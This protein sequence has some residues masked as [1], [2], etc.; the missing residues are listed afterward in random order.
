MEQLSFTDLDEI[1]SDN[2]LS[3]FSL[4][5]PSILEDFPF[6]EIYEVSRK[7]ASRKKPIFFIHKYFA[8]R[9]T[10]NFRLALLSLLFEGETDIWSKFYDSNQLSK[11]DSLTI[12]D[13][14]M[15]G[16]TTIFE[17]LRIGANVIGNDLQPLSRLVTE[18]EVR[19]LDE[20]RLKRQLDILD[21]RVGKKIK[22]Y[23]KTDCPQCDK[24]ADVMYNFHVKQA[25][26]PTSGRI[27]DLYSS[28]IIVS[29][30]GTYTLCCPKC[31]SLFKNDFQNGQ[32]DCP[33]CNY[34][35]DSPNDGFVKRGEYTCPETGE[36]FMLR[37][38]DSSTGYP[39]KT[40]LIAQE[41]YCTH[42]K[43]HDY[44]EVTEK[45]LSIHESALRDFQE[46]EKDLI[47]PEQE[48]PAGYNTNQ[49]INHG[50]GKFRDLFTD[51]QLL[52]LGLLLKEID[53]LEDEESK[54]WLMV[55]FSAQL[56]MNNTFC[57]YQHNA[58]KISNIFFNHAYV[59]ISMPVENNIWGT[60]LGT[61]T[62]IKGVNKIIKGKAFNNNIYD[63]SVSNGKSGKIFSKDK[64]NA[65]PV[66]NY[67]KLDKG[68]PLITNVDSR[69][70]E[71]IPSNS[72][73]VILTDPPYGSNVMY[74]ELI[75][76]FHV[77]IS[78]TD[79]GKDNG[80]ITP[81]SPKTEEV[82]VNNVQKKTYDD[83][84]DGLTEIFQEGNRTLKDEGYLMFT[85]HDNSLNGW[86]SV[87][88]SL[89]QSNFELVAAYP[90]HSET[91]TGAHTSAKNSIAFDIFLVCRKKHNIPESDF[92][93]STIEAN[94]LKITNNFVERLNNINAE[95]T[96][97]DIENIFI[98]QFFVSCFSYHF[99]SWDTLDNIIIQIKSILKQLDEVFNDYNI[100]EKRTGWWSNTQGKV[101]LQ[102]LLNAK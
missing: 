80:F 18:A 68:N 94:A 41:Y 82:I 26:S 81:T 5:N 67:K 22:S 93:F 87:I 96:I 65:I 42:C 24:E 75:D 50:Y 32:A 101:F 2:K 7:E 16:G 4:Q 77:W 62:F 71:H 28:F 40:K 11:E 98:S 86:I 74:S 78:S 76:F 20:K 29:K 45:D 63:I 38:L 97:R 3:S 70:L 102:S 89:I 10:C 13:P 1:Q 53:S 17:S 60:K 56:E 91:R 61:G 85:F 84:A 95:I 44:K 52:C 9:T 15:G 59:P 43:S 19:P 35:I 8:R 100:V 12:L 90:I 34:K 30:K 36:S 47:L 51:K 54:F 58:S 79:F 83:Y 23:F 27:H 49:M 6:D 69:N 66:T 73:D 46:L 99:S 14:F 88:K 72:V 33:N 57:R 31:N 92:S 55:A 64:V 39:K 21:K 25:L 37:D 48:I